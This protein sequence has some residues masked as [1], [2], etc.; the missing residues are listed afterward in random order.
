MSH[1]ILTL[2]IDNGQ[3][4]DNPVKTNLTIDVPSTVDVE[5]TNNQLS[6]NLTGNIVAN[7]GSITNRQC[8]A[9]ID[10]TLYDLG[11]DADVTDNTVSVNII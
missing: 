11:I 6:L 1:N 2:H 3:K 9:R 8:S 5:F 4:P 7:I 10:I